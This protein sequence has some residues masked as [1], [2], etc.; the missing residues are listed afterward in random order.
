MEGRRAGSIAQL[1]H[2]GPPVGLARGA[3]GELVR[4]RWGCRRRFGVAH[5]ASAGSLQP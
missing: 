5:G 4:W 2:R 3:C 1:R